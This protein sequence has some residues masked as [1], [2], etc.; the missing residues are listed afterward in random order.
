MDRVK[1]VPVVIDALERWNKEEDHTLNGRM[2]LAHIGMSGHSFGAVTTQAMAGQRF[3]DKDFSEK[4]IHAAVMMSPSKPKLGSPENAFGKI[5]IPCLLMTGTRDNSPIGGGTPED[6][7]EVFPALKEAPAWQVVF[8]EATH[9][10][11]GDR[12]KI[13][14]MRKE[15]RYHEAIL[16]LTTAFFDA[17]LKEEKAAMKWLNGEGANRALAVEDV[18]KTSQK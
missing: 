9:M 7:L 3:G 12:A 2:D 17:H 10:D 4:R 16:A 6:R 18:W 13:G 1:D 15:S 8:D 14:I 5:K 11:F